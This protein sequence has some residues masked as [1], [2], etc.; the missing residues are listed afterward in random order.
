VGFVVDRVTLIEV[1]LRVLSVI[2]CQYYLTTVPRFLYVKRLKILDFVGFMA[3]FI[4]SETVTLL[5]TLYK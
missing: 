3:W 1:P 2:L 5:L 4:K